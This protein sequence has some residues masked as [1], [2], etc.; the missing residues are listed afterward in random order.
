M[1]RIPR[2]QSA[3]DIYHVGSRGVGQQNIFRDDDDR[4]EFLGILGGSLQQ[5]DGMLFAWCLMTNHY[6]ILLQVGFSGLRRF[7]AMLNAKYARYFNRK[8]DRAGHLFQE[9]YWS[10]PIESESR[11]LSCA[12]YIHQNPAKAKLGSMNEYPWSSYHDYITTNA[13]PDV[14][15]LVETSLLSDMFASEES[16]RFF[17]EQGTDELFSE[18]FFLKRM[19]DASALAVAQEVLGKRE[20][21]ELPTFETRRQMQDLRMLKEA[22]LSDRQL[23]RLTGISRKIIRSA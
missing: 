12:R 2:Q 8:Y 18:G 16:M 9:R 19:S 21:A 5:N 17:S 14:P 10:E 23:Q 6:H 22:G 7:A 15:C 1:S 4:K 20:Y 3:T 11:F 13:G